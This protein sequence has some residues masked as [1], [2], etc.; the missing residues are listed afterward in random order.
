MNKEKK[1]DRIGVYLVPHLNE[2]IFDELSDSYLDRAGIGDILMGIPIPIRRTA[3]KSLTTLDIARN[4]AF[5]IGCD[6]DFEYKENYIAYILRTFGKKFAE[7]LIHDGVDGA[8]K[9]DFDY[10]CIQF[11]AAM[12]IDPENIDAYYCYGRA[13]KDSY[14]L[15]EE[16][17]Y[18]G[19]YKAESLEA[20]ELVTLKKPDFA[21][22]YYFLGYGYINLG[23]Y[24]KAK[25]TWDSFMEFS[26][27]DEKKKEIQGRLDTLTDPIEIEKGYN[28]VLSG[29]YQEGINI[30]CQYK[31]GKF[32]NWWPLWYYLGIAYQ[33]I[34]LYDEAILHFLQV[35]KLS[36]SNIETM[37]ELVKL[38][39][40]IGDRKKAEK[41]TKKI[42]VVKNNAA[43]DKAEAEAQAASPAE[44]LN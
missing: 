5:V 42:Q 29:R 28:F 38:Y 44:I 43:L 27:D 11:R 1:E 37:E 21:D 9:S 35:L 7:G 10:A 33:Q 36:P 4:M 12:Q 15:G 23:L 31:E 39:Q 30:L 34:H 20:F 13:C 41:Y 24:V 25:L 3:L 17:E 22:G 8:Q 18:V 2:F 26:S 32:S 19:R 14:E 6:P 16:E 40:E